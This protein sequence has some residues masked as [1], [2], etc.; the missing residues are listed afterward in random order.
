MRNGRSAIVR[1]VGALLVVLGA[2]MLPGGAAQSAEEE[3]D[4]HRHAGGPERRKQR[5][6]AG[7]GPVG[8]AGGRGDQRQGRR[9]GPEGPGDPARRRE[10]AGRRRESVQHG[11]PAAQGRRDHHDGDER[12]PQR[13]RPHRRPGEDALHLHFLLRGACVRQEPLHQCLGAGAGGAAAHQ[14]HDRREQGQEVVRGR[15]RLRL[16]A[17]DDRAGQEHDQGPGGT[18]SARST[19]RSSSPTGRRSSARSAR[20]TRTASSTPP[21]AAGRT[22]TS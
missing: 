20:P 17:R 18:W 4:R 12:R 16:R 21:R 6:G 22:S 19:S 13:G 14:V 7:R 5:R 2:A 9:A 11:D 10:R 15:Q 3:A 1:T 8:G